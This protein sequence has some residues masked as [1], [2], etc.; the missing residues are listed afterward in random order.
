MEL[1]NVYL[2]LFEERKVFVMDDNIKGSR[3]QK[4]MAFEQA[5]LAVETELD[6]AGLTGEAREETRKIAYEK[7][8]AAIE[9]AFEHPEV[10]LN[11]E[12]GLDELDEVAGGLNGYDVI[13]TVAIGVGGSIIAVST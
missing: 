2:K 11:K 3:S 10:Y 6:K 4:E 8:V 1:K 7:A 13:F 5:K 9:G 12:L